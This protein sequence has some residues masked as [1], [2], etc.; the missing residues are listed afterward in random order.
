M[1]VIKIQKTNSRKLKIMY[2]CTVVTIWF[3]KRKSDY[4]LVGVYVYNV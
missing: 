4:K 1:F 2:V 3:G